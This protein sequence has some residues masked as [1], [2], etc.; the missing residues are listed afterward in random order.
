MPKIK[1][2]EFNVGDFILY[3]GDKRWEH[4]KPAH[5]VIINKH[6]HLEDQYVY[7]AFDLE[8]E[9]VFSILNDINTKYY[10]ILA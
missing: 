1:N 5:M 8:C 3:K 2:L 9:Q 10:K 6:E 7:D 4:S